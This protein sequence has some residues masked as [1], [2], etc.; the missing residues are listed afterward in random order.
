VNEDLNLSMDSLNDAPSAAQSSSPPK[1]FS[2]AEIQAGIDDGTLTEAGAGQIRENQRQATLANNVVST[3]ENRAA[4]KE[5]AAVIS[6]EVNKYIDAFPEVKVEG[7]AQR[8]KVEKEFTDLVNIGYDKDDPRTEL[9]ALK[10]AFGPTSMLSRT[11]NITAHETHQEG[12]S[13]IGDN[14]ASKAGDRQLGDPSSAPA[15]LTPRQHAHYEGLIQRGLMGNWNE[16]REELKYAD[17][18]IQ[19]RAEVMN[20]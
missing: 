15:G 14:G 11:S 12:G 1:V 18:G 16:V 5:Q 3:I 13:G 7:A 19:R 6:G 4:A 20:V 8:E 10:S 9:L 17:P 2:E